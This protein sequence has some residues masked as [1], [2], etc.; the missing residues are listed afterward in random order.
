VGRLLYTGDGEGGETEREGSQPPCHAR[1]F[2][3]TWPLEVLGQGRG[4]LWQKKGK[5]RKT[6]KV[7]R[8]TACHIWEGL[9]LLELIKGVDKGRAG[10]SDC[11]FF[12]VWRE[13]RE[14]ERGD[15]VQFE[16]RTSAMV[17]EG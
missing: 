16:E 2:C 11:Y 10:R 9:T 14:V 3:H 6:P 7:R 8:E 4:E 12:F 15:A 17:A 5:K 13:S 1:I